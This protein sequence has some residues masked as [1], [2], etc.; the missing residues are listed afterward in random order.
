M[1]IASK[2]FFNAFFCMALLLTGAALASNSINGWGNLTFGMTPQEAKKAEPRLDGD[3]KRPDYGAYQIL[4][5][6]DA[7]VE[8][9]GRNYSLSTSFDVNHQHDI[10]RLQ[11][12][13][14]IWESD[15]G[16]AVYTKEC[17][18]IF[19]EH[20]RMLVRKYGSFDNLN[21][22]NPLATDD[23][24]AKKSV[25]KSTADGSATYFEKH[26]T[27]MSDFSFEAVKTLPQSKTI[28]VVGLPTIQGE[29]TTTC[30]VD[31]TFF[32]DLPAYIPPLPE[33]SNAGDSF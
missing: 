14:L 19:Q 7:A 15:A 26:S 22:K 30:R 9:A 10:M 1:N 18:N 31:I 21:I 12:I 3:L 27:M 23:V 2:I 8:I 24:D 5:S 13:T 4:E 16:D 11:A 6:K 33:A 17:E 20:L 32:K 29:K 25:V 28:R